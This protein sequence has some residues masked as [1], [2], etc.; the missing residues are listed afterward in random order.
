[1]FLLLKYRKSK[2]TLLKRKALFQDLLDSIAGSKELQKCPPVLEFFG[3]R[4]DPHY[5]KYS[6]YLLRIESEQ[7]PE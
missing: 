1:M 4:A 6:P 7:Q 3:V 2:S 5:W